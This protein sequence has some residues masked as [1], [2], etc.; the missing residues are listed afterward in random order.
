[1]PSRF[2]AKQMLG[3]VKKSKNNTDPLKDIEKL[4]KGISNNSYWWHAE[5]ISGSVGDPVQTWTDRLRSTALTQGVL[6]SRPLISTLNGIRALLFDDVNDAIANTSFSATIGAP[7]TLI[8]VQDATHTDTL[9]YRRIFSSVGNTLDLSYSTAGID[10]IDLSG[11]GISSSLT[12][13]NAGRAA[14]V[15]SA[16]LST[17]TSQVIINTSA[18]S[19]NIATITGSFSGIYIGNRNTLD[20]AYSGRIADVL[21]LPGASVGNTSASQIVTL[22][23]QYYGIG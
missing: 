2:F 5:D 11:S 20:R 10:Q 14:Q 22:L 13:P 21:I 19:Q 4:I 7:V 12:V 1:M 16:V 8:F 15:T 9:R 6:A 17:P 23:M 3:V 18:T